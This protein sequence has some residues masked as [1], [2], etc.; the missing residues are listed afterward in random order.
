M[1]MSATVTTPACA[2]PG[3]KTRPGFVAAKVT[4]RSAVITGPSTAPVSPSAPDGMST[5]TTS[6][7]AAAIAP[8]TQAASPASAP[9]KPVPNMASTTTSARPSAR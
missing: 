9:R 8:T 1:P 3:S 5:A 4:V 6:T 2:R 7:G